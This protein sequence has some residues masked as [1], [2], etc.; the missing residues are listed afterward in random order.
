MCEVLGHFF[1]RVWIC[2]ST[3]AQSEYHS[4]TRVI[5]Q[6]ELTKCALICIECKLLAKQNEN[7]CILKRAKSFLGKMDKRAEI[8]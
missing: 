8:V 5:F 2:F 7:T 6:Y 1:S 4:L 3:G